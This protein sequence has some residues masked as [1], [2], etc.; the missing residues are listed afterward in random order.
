MRENILSLLG[1]MRRANA[2]AVGEVNT[3]GAA[4]SGKAKLLLLA[5][6]ASENARHRAEGFAAGRDIPLS[7]LPFTK[8]AFA[9]A[10]GLSGGSMAAVTDLGFA[11]A[12]LKALAEDEPERYGAAA[13]R[14]EER[15]ARARANTQVRTKRIGKR[16]TDA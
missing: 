16:R 11:R 10:V 1:L 2:I 15:Y 3:G 7:T 8:E 6:D 4:K 9:S 13:Q 5:A 14:M 12:L